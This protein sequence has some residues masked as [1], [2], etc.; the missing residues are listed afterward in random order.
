MSG[1]LIRIGLLSGCLLFASCG[2]GGGGGNTNAT[3]SSSAPSATVPGAPTGLVGT[4]GDGTATLSFVA[5]SSDGGAAISGYTGTCAAGSSSRSATGAA[6]PITINGLSN[7]TS[8]TCSVVASNRVGSGTSSA[9]V[10]VTPLGASASGDFPGNIVLGA[11]TSNSIRL[12]LYSAEQSGSVIVSY[13]AEGDNS[14]R[15]TAQLSLTRGVV[16]DVELSGLKAGAAY[17]Y[18]VLLKPTVGAEIQ[19]REFRFQTARA[20]GITFSFTIQ[21]DSHLDENSDLDIYKKT[22]ANILADQGDFHIDLGDT[23]M[24]EKHSEPLSAVVSQ[25]TSKATL[26]A[27]YVYERGNFGLFSHSIPLFLVNGNHDAELGWLADGTQQNIAVWASK[28][29]LEYFPIPQPGNFYSG[30]SFVDPNAGNRVAWYSWAWGDAQIIVLDPFW[31]TKQRANSDPWNFTLGEK[32]Y[33]WLTETLASSTAKF[34]II[35]IHNLVGGLDGAMRGGVEAAPYY[36]WGGKNLDGTS[37]FASRRPGWALPIHDLLVKYKV[38]AVFHGHDHLYAKQELD[39]IVYQTVPQPSAR[40]FNSGATLAKDYHYDTGTILSSS[41]HLRITV[42]PQLMTARYIRSWLPK[43]E[44]A[45]RRN[46]QV[47]HEWSVSRP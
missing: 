37:G 15:Q 6:S 34:K 17:R 42:T 33:Q 1:S 5:P 35:F 12:K 38:A 28:A 43:D 11:P 21:A 36:E 45:S 2:G 16:L 24:T 20:P 30:D 13:R 29:R 44:N 9:S 7:G 40:N 26:D 19:S 31:N 3:G 23:F 46:G 25:P 32:Q 10:T 8:Y 27:R 39:G 41:G 18:R 22:L 14:D 4:V 47:E